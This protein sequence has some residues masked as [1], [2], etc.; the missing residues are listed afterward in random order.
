MNKSVRHQTKCGTDLAPHEGETIHEVIQRLG[1]GASLNEIL[2]ELQ[3]LGLDACE[4]DVVDL[5]DEIMRS[6][7]GEV[8][9]SA[10]EWSES[11]E[12]SEPL[13]L[14]AQKLLHEAGSLARAEHVLK[15]IE[16]RQQEGTR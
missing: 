11:E 3:R 4:D 15:T 12:I 6:Q 8:Q 14:A 16:R 1:A 13:V 10:V 2:A 7:S 5:R 9:D